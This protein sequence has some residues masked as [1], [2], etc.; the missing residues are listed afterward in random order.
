[1]ANPRI[2]YVMSSEH[3][4]LPPM[5]GKRILVHLV[6]NVEHWQFDRWQLNRRGLDCL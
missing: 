1:M 2:P 6:V 3:P 5:Q 4:K